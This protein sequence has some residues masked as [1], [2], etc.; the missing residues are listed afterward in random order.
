MHQAIFHFPR[1]FLWGTAT[2]AH[3]V[4]GNNTKNNWWAWEQEPG[5][6]IYDH[7]SGRACDWWGGRWRED[8][9]LAAAGGQNAHRLSIEWSRIQ[10]A[11]D[12]WDEAALD[13]YRDMLRGMRERGLTPM[14]TLHHF[15][16]PLWIAEKGSWENQTIAKHYETYVRKVVEA[17]REYVNLWITINEPNVLAVNGYVLGAFPPG[18]KDLGAG[19]RSLTNLLRAHAAGYQAI[20]AQQPQAKVGVAINYRGFLAA[21]KWLPLDNW[22]AGMQARIFNEAFPQALASGI[23]RLPFGRQRIPEAKGTQDFI[24]I[25]Y[26]T[27]DQVSFNLFKAKELFGRRFYLPEAEVSETGF[28][29]NDPEGMFEALKWGRQ[30]NLP[31]MVTENGVEDASDRLRPRYLAQHIHQVWRAVN[32]NWPVKGYFHW[33]LVDNFEWE[34]GWTQRF[35]LWELNTETQAR[36]KRPSADFYAEI[37]KQNGISTEM[38]ARYAPEIV[39]EMFPV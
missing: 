32:Y 26:Y 16:D 38:I 19:L 23:L 2:A 21:K 31:M 36:Y 34:R 33:T 7:K 11:P 9:D 14:V 25:N 15:S 28:I 6:I 4:E 5:R 29:A 22:S 17:L 27:R 37:C 35:G 24:G 12:R 20:H 39:E 1:G 13:R 3:Q 8:F 10:P 18:K 30:F